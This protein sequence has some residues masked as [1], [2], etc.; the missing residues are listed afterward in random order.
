M[1]E[2]SDLSR[3]F[4]SFYVCLS[5]FDL[6]FIFIHRLFPRDTAPI[7]QPFLSP[8]ILAVLWRLSCSGKHGADQHPRRWRVS[9]ATL[10]RSSR[11]RAAR[12][13][14][15][16]QRPSL[17]NRRSSIGIDT[18]EKS[19]QNAIL[20][21]LSSISCIVWFLFDDCLFIIYTFNI[22]LSIHL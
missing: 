17:F 18:L 13:K 22:Y 11:A 1:R 14:W 10:W 6:H 12:Q 15:G 4:L 8:Y 16:Q 20:K 19:S 21:T 7:E 5:Q 9:T 3:P 2:I